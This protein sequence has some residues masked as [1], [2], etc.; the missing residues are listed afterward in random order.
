MSRTGRQID[1]SREKLLSAQSEE[2]SS[3]TFHTS[4]ITDLVL[5]CYSVSL[6][7][8]PIPYPLRISH[9][10]QF[11]LDDLDPTLVDYLSLYLSVCP[12]RHPFWLSVSCGSQDSTIQES[13]PHKCGQKVS[14]K[15]FNAV[16]KLS[17]LIFQDTSLSCVP[18]MP[19]CISRVFLGRFLGQQIT[20]MDLGLGQPRMLSF[21]AQPLVSL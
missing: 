4:L 18:I 1:F 11:P 5:D 10:I 19:I 9:I 15:T 8:F 3:Y 13:S 7:I 17:P 16:V 12:I 2:M 14:Y 6:V 21:L 20:S